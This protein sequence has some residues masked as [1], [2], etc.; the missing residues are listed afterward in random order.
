MVPDPT[1]TIRERA[2]A[3][4]P[5]AWHGHQLR[6]VLVALGYDVDVPWQDLPREQRD[7]ILYTEE[8]PFV[9][10][11]SRLT[12]DEARA[13]IAAG[14]EPTYSGTYTGARR[15]VLDTFANTKSA[16]MKRRVA[17][18][19]SAA[20][21]PAC[22][23]KRLKPEALS[24][25]IAGLD[26]A[27]F[28]ELPLEDATTLLETAVAEAADG[29]GDRSAE[30]RAATARLGAGLLDRIRPIIDLGLGYL[31]L[32]R[33]TPTLSGGELQRLRLAIQLTSELF[34]VVY[35]LDEP[36]AGLHPQDVHALLGILDGLRERGNSL[37]VVEHSVDVM[38]HA[39]WLV[40]IGPGAGERGG[41]VLYSGPPDG[42]AHVEESV[43]RGYLAGGRGLP[44]HEPRTLQGRLRLEGVTRNNLR[45]V[46]VE[47]PLHVLTAV[48]GVSGSGKSSLVS[49]VLP[50]LVGEHLGRPV[51]TDEPAPDDDALLLADEPDELEGSVAGDLA[52]IRRV[53]SIDQKPIG[54]TP[55]SNVATYTGLFDHVRRRFAG[56]PEAQARGYKPG[57]FSFNVAGGRCP[58]CEGEGSVMVE[59]LFLPSVYAE[60]PDCHGTRYQASTLEITWRGLDIAQILALSVEEAREFFE[61]EFDIMRSL[62]ALH[63]VGLGYLRLGQP[64]TELSGGEAQRVKLASELQRAQRGD[65][66]YVLDEPTSGLHSADADRLVTHLQSLVDAGNTVVM[67]ELDMRVIA[68]ADHVIDLGPGAGDDGGQVV[69]AGTPAQ[70]AASSDSVSARFLATALEETAAVAAAE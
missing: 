49:Q 65:T 69:A 12:L 51:R 52:G 9:P 46:S 3:A 58:T 16:S 31:S 57:R 42:L 28:S 2:I 7:W 18:F 59:L 36:S 22:H 60:C 56:T 23:G 14:V 44:P 26:I 17:E 67:V 32:D 38:R 48:T 34:G 8:T 40:D 5:T 68:Q 24:V 47:I 45:N 13:A 25:T 43:T 10:V 63:D 19:L 39:D 1:L 70:V 41:R 6:D 64:A 15:Y 30:Q 4:H 27:Q 54:R 53:V 62:T 21:C 29:S 35:V 55:R 37:F 66:L 61:G 50:A 33:T 20:P 11:H